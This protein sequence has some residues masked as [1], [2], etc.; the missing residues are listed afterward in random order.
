MVP[1][2]SLL[3]LLLITSISGFSQPLDRLEAATV[4]DFRG[5]RTK[6]PLPSGQPVVILT[7]GVDCPITQKYV[8][9]LNNLKTIFGKEMAFIGIFPKEFSVEEMNSFVDEYKLSLPCFIDQEM[10][11]SDLLNAKVT[12]EAFLLSPE[13]AKLYTG[14]IDNWFYKLGSYRSKPTHHYLRDALTSALKGKT[15]VVTR[16]EAIGCPIAKSTGH[17]KHH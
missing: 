8:P 9:T 3:L 14:A 17:H 7:L 4:I 5:Q 2:I 10:H 13:R 15:I 11:V 1:R 16:T 6:L 12:P